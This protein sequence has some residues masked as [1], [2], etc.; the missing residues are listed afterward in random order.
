MEKE[1]RKVKI[2]MDGI[3]KDIK[4]KELELPM[5]VLY[6]LTLFFVV[7]IIVA[8]IFARS[9]LIYISGISFCIYLAV[10]IADVFYVFYRKRCIKNGKFTVKKDKLVDISVADKGLIFLTRRGNYKNLPYKLKFATCLPRFSIMGKLMEN[11]FFKAYVQEFYYEWSV[12]TMQGGSVGK[13]GDEYYLVFLGK[14]KHPLY[15]LQHKIFLH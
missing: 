8:C 9:N 2:T 7:G 15:D 13:I 14:S 6:W 12:N 10:L 1:I 11:I 5:G 3:K 4:F